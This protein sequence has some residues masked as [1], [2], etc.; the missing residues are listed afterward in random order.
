M[1]CKQ[2]VLQKQLC[3]TCQIFYKAKLSNLKSMKRCIVTF[4]SIRG[5]Q[6]VIWKQLN[7]YLIFKKHG[8][9]FR[10]P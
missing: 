9:E 8:N 6:C 10:V 1:V 7:S 2:K 4:A 3:V 5:L